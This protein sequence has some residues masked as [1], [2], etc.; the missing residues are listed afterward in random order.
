[1][2]GMIERRLRVNYLWSLI[3][4]LSYILI[5]PYA[6]AGSNNAARL[7]VTDAQRENL[8]QLAVDTPNH[9]PPKVIFDRNN[10]TPTLIKIKSFTPRTG[11]RRAL[12]P[13][14][15]ET[16]ARQFIYKNRALLKI[17]DPD[18]ELNL[19]KSWS[20]QQGATHF[21]Y[22]QMVGDVPVFGK[23]LLVHA[24]SRNSIYLLNGRFEPTP[25]ALAT[26]PAITENDAV[27][28]VRQ[29]LGLSDIFPTAIE[30]SVFTKPNGKMVLTYKIE[31]APT[32]AESWIYFIDA[33]N[34]EFVHRLTKIRNEIVSARGVDLN[35]QSQ[36]FNAWHHTDNRFYLIDPGLPGPQGNVDDSLDYVGNPDDV[37][38]FQAPGNTYIL[39]ANGTEGQELAQIG[40]SSPN[41]PWDATGVSAMANLNIIHNYYHGEPFGRNGWDD[42]Y[43]DYLVFVHWGSRE[44]NA[45]FGTTDDGSGILA[46]GDGDGQVMSGL[47]GGLDVVAHEFQHGVTQYTA[48]LIYENQSGAIDEGYSDIFACMVDDDDWTVGDDVVLQDPQFLRNLADPT[49]G[50]DRLPTKMSEYQ[51]LPNTEEGDYG[52]VHT[53]MSIPSHAAYLMAEGLNSSIG[54]AATAQIWYRALTYL[55]P[56]SEFVDA[57]IA[58]LQ[59]AEELFGSNEVAAVQAAWDEVEVYDDGTTP[60]APTEITLSEQSF[61]F[62][63]VSVGRQVSKDLILSNDSERNINI[64][65][66]AITGSPNFTHDGNIGPL[67]SHQE[68]DIEVTYRPKKAGSDTATL[69]ITSDADIPT[70]NISIT[71]QAVSDHKDDDGNGAGGCF[72]CTIASRP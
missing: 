50:L 53:N 54:R 26:T 22:Q 61:S 18:Q 16:T 30:L 5:G 51:D 72:I 48:G 1:M 69:S 70:D 56:D 33:N 66:I 21:K 29:H 49:Q 9:T 31:V 43:M 55:T 32:L 12:A 44:A 3:L 27:E 7:L 23:Q 6:W 42:D 52:G 67:P 45:F 17:D 28:A 2:D 20:D 59:A 10:G 41:G 63:N 15:V 47:S 11:Q 65:N 62:S 19:I 14:Q 35:G 4:M 34:G 24:D 13:G 60:V 40:A 39:S 8:L 46:F 68:M 38:I 25:P 64:D 37:Q 57:R 58:T 71:G 36:N